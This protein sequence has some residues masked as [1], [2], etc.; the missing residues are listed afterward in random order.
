MALLIVTMIIG[1]WL[2]RKKFMYLHEAGVATII[3]ILISGLL[4]LT[5][6]SDDLKPVTRLNVDVF[7]LFL[8][9]PIIFESG[10]SMDK[11]PFFKNFGGIL[12][13]AFNGTFISAVI[14]CVMIWAFG[15]MSGVC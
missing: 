4:E 10:Y 13:Y 7:L 8:L 14:V 6:L 5:G 2:K 3:G 1:Y 11:K 9:P 15:Q 12:M